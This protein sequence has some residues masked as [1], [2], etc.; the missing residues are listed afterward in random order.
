[1]ES[2]WDLIPLEMQ[3]MIID[4]KVKQEHNEIFRIIRQLGCQSCDS[5]MTCVKTQFPNVPIR[6]SFK[7]YILDSEVYLRLHG[8]LNKY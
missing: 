5:I 1:M 8:Y 2:F 6:I 7:K 4:Y 3:E